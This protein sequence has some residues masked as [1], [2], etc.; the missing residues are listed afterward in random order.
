VSGWAQKTFEEKCVKAQ[1]LTQALVVLLLLAAACDEAGICSIGKEAEGCPPGAVC[2]GGE[3]AKKGSKGICVYGE[4]SPEGKPVAKITAWTLRLPNRLPVEPKL[5]DTKDVEGEGEQENANAGWVGKGAAVV[6]VTLVGAAPEAALKA[7]ARE[8]VYA[9]C[10]PPAERNLR[11]EVWTCAFGAG[12]AAE[13][14]QAREADT[15]EVKLQV[16]EGEVRQRLYR[17]DRRAPL[18]SWV[19]LGNGECRVG[20]SLCP[21]G[22]ACVGLSGDEGEVGAVGT[23]RD[24]LWVEPPIHLCVQAQDLQSG[25]LD[26][27][28]QA[29]VATLG[30]QVLELNWQ[31]EGK[32][33]NAFSSCWRG[34]LPAGT[35]RREVHFSMAV[36]ARNKADNATALSLEGNLEH[37]CSLDLAGLARDSVTQPLAMSGKYLLFSTSTG[38]TS[39]AVMAESGLYVFDTAACAFVGS[40]HTGTLA[41]VVVLGNSGR[42]ALAIRGGGPAGRN[43]S[44]L[45][46]VEMS[47][48]KPGFVYEAY[49]DCMPGDGGS[50]SDAVFDKGISLLGLGG[51]NGTGW[52]FV[53]PANSMAKNSAHLLAY[54][55][56]DTQLFSR[57]AASAATPYL[58]RAPVVQRGAEAQ[59]RGE[60]G[61]IVTLHH[62]DV[63]NVSYTQDWKFESPNWA[64]VGNPREQNIRYSF[65]AI[66][67]T[68]TWRS[69]THSSIDSQSRLYTVA[70][71]GISNAE[72]QRR[73]LNPA[74]GTIADA[75]VPLSDITTAPAV[76]SALLGEPPSGNNEDTEVYVV[77]TDGKVL[78]FNAETLGL[79]WV[80]SLGIDIS[81]TAAPVLTPHEMGGGIL[82][83][84]GMRGEVRGTRVGSNGLNR[85]AAWPKAFHDNCNTNSRLTTATSLPSCF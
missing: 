57:C 82:W 51:T 70:G 37:S 2:Y 18:L 83:V 24:M 40:L 44:R 65:L 48:G 47:K 81:P 29:P 53:V 13:E 15:V 49:M 23:C 25:M 33:A 80:E 5:W 21:E 31:Q 35:H 19:V 79:L 85:N 16:G 72:F 27:Q 63:E 62:S 39:D 73:V 6:E 46:L 43:G 66:S 26:I 56:D 34:I 32:T 61:N 45:A 14:S 77:T 52:R 12:W 1:K 50:H 78:A 71:L 30:E 75:Q 67:D 4:L 8:A 3:N 60:K 20:D 17:V 54:T 74:G 38:G 7:W 55:P 9:E 11:G 28:T 42:V 10:K 84:V 22:H 59:S 36:E 68:A 69:T 76:G 64:T 41:P 58:F